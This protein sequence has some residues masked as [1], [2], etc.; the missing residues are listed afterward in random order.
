MAMSFVQTVGRRAL[1]ALVFGVYLGAAAGAWAQA[2]DLQTPRLTGQLPGCRMVH[3][4]G[5]AHIGEGRLPFLVF[6]NPLPVTQRVEITLYDSGTHSPTFVQD[7]PP[8][9]S[10]QTYLHSQIPYLAK[11][12]RSISATVRWE[13]G[14]HVHYVTQR[15]PVPFWFHDPIGWVK[16]WQV[17][18]VSPA[19]IV[20][21]CEV[22]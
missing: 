7:V 5:E 11:G 3:L 21:I 13:L 2:P 18:L 9:R 14:G 6:L 10:T 16:A 8:G 20:P 17:E 15:V 19:T 4:L 22:P 1:G 12:F